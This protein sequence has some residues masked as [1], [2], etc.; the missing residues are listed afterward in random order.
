MQF[1]KIR[2]VILVVILA[3][4]V[5][6][7]FLLWPKNNQVNNNIPVV[8]EN[9]SQN[10]G[11]DYFIPS[12]ENYDVSD[13]NARLA[14]NTSVNWYPKEKSLDDV[15]LV[16]GQGGEVSYYLLGEHSDNK[17][18]MAVAPALD[19]SGPSI[20]FFEEKPDGSYVFMQKMSSTY[21][22]G[23]VLNGYAQ[24]GGYFLS[25]EIKSTDAKTVY[26]G[27][28]GPTS[29][30]YSGLKLK[31]DYLYVSD[32]FSKYKIS[33][34]SMTKVASLAEGDLYMIQQTSSPTGDGVGF[35]IRRFVLKLPSGLYTL[36][37]VIY[38]FFSD[39]SVPNI[40]WSD[41][42]KN[43]DYYRK[44][45]SLGGCGNPGSYVVLSYDVS[46]LV[47]AAGTTS[48]GETIYELTDKND[49]VLKFFYGLQG[50][51]IYDPDAGLVEISFEEWLQHHPVVFYK[52]S[53]ED[54]A[55][56]TN[57]KYGIAAECGKPV[58]YLYPEKSMPVSVKVGA[59]ITKS[60]PYY[61]TGWDV[62][63]DPSGII[64]T[65]DGTTYNSLFWEGIGHGMYPQSAEG[66]VV[67][68]D[69]LKNTLA[70]QLKELGLSEKESLDFLEF[71]LPKMPNTPFVRLT[72]FTNNQLDILA[73]LVINPAPDT[74]IR[75]FLD[76]QGLDKQIFLPAQKLSSIPRSGF[77]V[78]EWGGILIK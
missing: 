10:N 74:V 7:A 43:Q 66:F 73:P 34:V 3:V 57:E 15:N 41:G 67:P 4:E 75:V 1:K 56:F 76:F 24:S 28:T 62:F 77:T 6:V 70:V 48:T 14:A 17:I 46:G 23:L 37:N 53:L 61:G 19:P 20:F 27:I 50:G 22:N 55:I 64:K 2:L 49:A 25:S 18:I 47:H 69:M 9:T 11:K 33:E 52:N 71:W 72:W 51:K 42:S 63:A 65:Q 29:L 26:R 8:S 68:Q 5:I 58:I 35:Y 12:P 78:V 44:D 32:L 36:Y 31:Q 54:Y 40:T 13:Y 59:S 16:M 39:N 45:A 60:D 21:I 30:N 38:S